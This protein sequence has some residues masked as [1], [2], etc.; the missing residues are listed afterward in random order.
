MC[1]ANRTRACACRSSHP[2][3]RTPFCPFAVA[4][5]AQPDREHGCRTWTSGATEKS[6]AFIND[7]RINLNRY[8]CEL[9]RSSD[10]ARFPYFLIFAGGKRQPATLIVTSCA[11]YDGVWWQCWKDDEYTTHP[12]GRTRRTRVC[13]KRRNLYKPFLF[14]DS[15]QHSII[16]T[17]QPLT[18]SA[19]ACS[20]RTA[21]CAYERIQSAQR[22]ARAQSWFSSRP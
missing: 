8:L 19:A 20:R 12:V 14:L 7:R 2:S 16:S 10:A 13:T 1:G 3:T 22:T 21:C 9:A 15:S 5:R 18:A 11:F 6:E 4:L 17:A